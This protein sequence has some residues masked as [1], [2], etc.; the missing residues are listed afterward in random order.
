MATRFPFSEAYPLFEDGDRFRPAAAV[1]EKH[2]P[3][4]QSLAYSSEQVNRLR[5]PTAKSGEDG[6]ILSKTRRASLSPFFRPGWPMPRPV[7]SPRS[8]SVRFAEF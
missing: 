6:K 3:V 5:T 4:A 1:S 7:T 2:Y 8:T